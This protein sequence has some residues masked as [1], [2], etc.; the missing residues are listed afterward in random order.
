MPVQVL[1]RDFDAARLN[2]RND[3]RARKLVIEKGLIIQA[4]FT[5]KLLEERNGVSAHSDPTTQ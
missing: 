1:L 5:E 3:R 2:P 4:E